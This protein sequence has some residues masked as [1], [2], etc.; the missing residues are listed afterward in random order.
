MK[1]LKLPA[2]ANVV[3]SENN[4]PILE[5]KTPI[6]SAE[7]AFQG[8]TLFHWQPLG[9]KPVI[10]TSEEAIFD[11]SKAIRG[12]IP[13]CWPWFGAHP[14]N[15]EKPQ[16]GFVRNTQ[17]ELESV[18]EL[19][20][21]G[22]VEVLF[23][24]PFNNHQYFPY[25]FDLKCRFVIG[26]TL[27]VHLETTNI[28]EEPFEVG[29]ALHTYFNVGDIRG[30]SITGLDKTDYLDKP[31]EN[32]LK[33]QVG[34]VV[35]GDETDRVYLNTRAD[36]LVKDSVGARKIKVSKENSNTT[37]VWNPWREKATALADM[38]DEEYQ[39][40][41]CVETVNMGEDTPQIQP[42]ESHA[43]IQKITIPEN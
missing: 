24:L 19:S 36:C 32:Q 22:F 37:V 27:Q 16:H 12:G 26:K 43:L 20:S 40:F 2:I 3:G 11:V 39:T 6:F 38:M 35:I 7:I 29:G 21:E 18:S 9:E 8:A 28:G 41:V 4:Y 14:S 10:F 33:T 17:W 15:V 30:V 31:D 1:N 42:G 25:Q 23:S 13:I 5:L 34:E